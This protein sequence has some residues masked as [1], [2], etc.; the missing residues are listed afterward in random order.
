MKLACGMGAG[1]ARLGYTCGAVTGAV[2][3]I[4]LRYGHSRPEDSADKET[5]YKVVR[6]FIDRFREK[7][8]TIVCRELLGCDIATPE[9]LSSAQAQGLFRSVCTGY[10]RDA[11]MLVESL[12]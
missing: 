11:V 5:T 8:G 9:G 6:E 3:A 10:V 7:H 12:V 4:G 1:F 2:M